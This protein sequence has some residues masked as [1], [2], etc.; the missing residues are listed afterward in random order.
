MK[1]FVIAILI[2]VCLVTGAIF[3]ESQLHRENEALCAMA[4]QTEWLVL[5]GETEQ[6][7][8]KLGMLKKRFFEKAPLRMAFSD[9]TKSEK[10]A[11]YLLE[12]EKKLETGVP[13]DAVSSLLNFHF[14]LESFDENMKIKWHNIL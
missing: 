2:F 10:M 1:V 9:H 14:L 11:E 6:A 5:R 12:A 13:E 3:S 8:E 7:R 4:K